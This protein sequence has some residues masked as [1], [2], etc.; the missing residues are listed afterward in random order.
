[1]AS[2]MTCC[3]N[4]WLAGSIMSLILPTPT[5]DSFHHPQCL[6]FDMATDKN[7]DPVGLLLRPSIVLVFAAAQLLCYERFSRAGD[8]AVAVSG[9]R[10]GI[11]SS[12]S[13][14]VGTDSKVV[15]VTALWREDRRTVLAS[16]SPS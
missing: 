14:S 10:V 13:S 4:F 9:S 5:F 15:H 7:G 1:M 6:L 8:G 12:V 11:G 2:W 16:R 3:N